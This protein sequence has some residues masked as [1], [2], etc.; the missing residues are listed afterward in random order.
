MGPNGSICHREGD[1]CRVQTWGSGGSG[2]SGAVLWHSAGKEG[3]EGREP[4]GP[5]SHE[6][7]LLVDRKELLKVQTCGRVLVPRAIWGKGY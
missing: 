4:R 5:R 7:Q 1:I 2:G 3:Q 6:P